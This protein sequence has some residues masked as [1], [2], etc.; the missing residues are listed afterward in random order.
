[1][2]VPNIQ[3][4]S[5]TPHTPQ[6]ML[7]PD[8]G[9]TPIR[10]ITE[11][12]THGEDLGSEPPARALRVISNARGNKMARNGASGVERRVA[13]REPNVVKVVRRIVA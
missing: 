5:D 8:H 3:S 10:R 12:R 9:T 2:K 1:M 11:R 7:M 4:L 6:A 13:H